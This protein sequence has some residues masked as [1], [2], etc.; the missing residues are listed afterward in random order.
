M[1]RRNE[2]QPARGPR[3]P[4]APVPR[5]AGDRPLGAGGHGDAAAVGVAGREQTTARDDYTPL[6]M[7][8]ERLQQGPR[9]TEGHP[10]IELIPRA[11][12]EIA[13]DALRWV[14]RPTPG[15]WLLAAVLAVLT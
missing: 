11:P 2:R 12:A 6:P 9:H 10:P 1:P 15:Y 5:P 7:G 14:A 8:A 13:A 3:R 4:T